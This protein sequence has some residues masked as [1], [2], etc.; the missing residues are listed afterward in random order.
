M[1]RWIVLCCVMRESV[2]KMPCDF[3]FW[4][5][6]NVLLYFHPLHHSPSSFRLP[7]FRSFI[8]YALVRLSSLSHFSSL[9]NVF[10]WCGW[11]C[12]LQSGESRKLYCRTKRE[13]K[14]IIQKNHLWSSWISILWKFSFHN[15]WASF[16]R[17]WGEKKNQFSFQMLWQQAWWTFRINFIQSSFAFIFIV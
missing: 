1:R 3:L 10:G 14:K 12:G 11:N 4:C 17:I 8:V 15:G 7:T 16:S 6:R 5:A 2:W 13:R 9:F